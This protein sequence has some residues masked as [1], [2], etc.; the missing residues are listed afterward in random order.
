MNSK[1]QKIY[2]DQESYNNL[3][4]EIE[5][6]K[7]ELRN[8][9]LGRK[10]AFDAGA[11]DGWDS[12]EFE[13]IERKER[14]IQSQLKE[15]YEMLS[16]AEIVKSQS[17][18]QIVDIGDI[19][20]LNMVFS[21]DDIEELKVKL[22]ASNNDDFNEDMEIITLNSPLG[23]AIYKKKIGEECTYS[24]NE[25]KFLVRIVEKLSFQKEEN[26]KKLVK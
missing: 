13:E 12:P 11:G 5:M 7:Q 16:N 1:E 20:L 21:D 19:L 9:N 22:V 8:T 26:V 23:Q 10:E 6:L 18:D 4:R 2:L 14:L 17:N 15:K 25:N 24:V 3:L